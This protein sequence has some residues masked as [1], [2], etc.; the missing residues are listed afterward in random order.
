M[1]VSFKLATL[2]VAVLTAGSAICASGS[3]AAPVSSSV[4]APRVASAFED[5][6]V[7]VQR[8]Y[9]NFRGP[10]IRRGYVGPRFV[11]PGPRYYGGPRYYRRGP[12]WGTGLA[13]GAGALVGAILLSEAA[14]AEYRRSGAWQRCA[15][16]Y[17]SFDWDTGTIVTYDGDVVLC[18]YLR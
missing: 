7:K 14:R 16:D 2:A 18:P 11:R 17:V 12:G 9:R 6:V 13:I 15:D 3:L 10:A 4:V 8:R 5:N 1:A